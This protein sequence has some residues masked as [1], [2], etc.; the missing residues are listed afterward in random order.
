MR[1]VRYELRH[2]RPDDFET[3]AGELLVDVLIVDPDG[4]PLGG[5]MRDA[6]VHHRFPDESLTRWPGFHLIRC[7]YIRVAAEELKRKARPRT[8]PP[9]WDA[10][11]GHQ[12][13]AFDPPFAPQEAQ[14]LV[15]VARIGPEHAALV[16]A[17]YRDVAQSLGL[18]RTA[19]DW[20]TR[21]AEACG[22]K[23]FRNHLRNQQRYC[24]YEWPPV[25]SEGRELSSA[26][27]AVVLAAGDSPGVSA[28]SRPHSDEAEPC[29]QLEPRDPKFTETAIRPGQGEFR[30]VCLDAFGRRCGLSGCEVEAALDAAHIV[31]WIDGGPHREGNMLLLRADLHRLFDRHELAISPHDLMPVLSP[32]LRT[33]EAYVDLL[34]SPLAGGQPNRRALREHLAVARRMWGEAA[35]DGTTP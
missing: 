24:G 11:H 5:V 3:R 15:V 23:D 8:E 19:G 12:V 22:N 20:R 35:A 16:E 28:S 31:P 29:L 17:A 13:A 18:S 32:R 2:D 27:P 26:M 9:Y 34:R 30:E 25:T 6:I 7:A 1:S 14:R 21:C 33:N 4:R 10:V